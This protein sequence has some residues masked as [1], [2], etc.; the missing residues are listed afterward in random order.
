MRG[1]EYPLNLFNFHSD[2]S[3]VSSLVTMLYL[4]EEEFVLPCYIFQSS[5]SRAMSRRHEPDN[6]MDFFN[7]HKEFKKVYL[8]VSF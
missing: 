4:S 2:P 5:P 1:E 8:P 3:G 7:V 6:L